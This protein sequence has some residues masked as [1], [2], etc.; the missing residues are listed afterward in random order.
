MKSMKHIVLIAVLF[1]LF[2]TA[3]Q[4]QGWIQDKKAMY[5]VG[6]GGTQVIFLPYQPRPFTGRGSLGLTLNI[7]GEY[8][9]HQIIGIGWQA[10]MNLFVNGRYYNKHDKFYYNSTVVGIPIGFKMNVHILE[11]TKATIK[12]K[13]DVYAGFNIGAGPSFHNDGVERRV[14]PFIYAGPQAGVRYWFGN[15]AVFG[16]IGWG[17]SIINAGITF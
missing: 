4:A 2:S 13:L 8:K 3:A 1:G 5:S 6:M 14:L 9:V 10:G 17:A 12:D 7:A 16:E 15:I 11:A